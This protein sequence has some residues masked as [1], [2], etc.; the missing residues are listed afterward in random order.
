MKMLSSELINEITYINKDNDENNICGC[1][2]TYSIY[3]I[4]NINKLSIETFING[5]TKYAI[6]S[7][8][9]NKIILSQIEGFDLEVISKEEICFNDIRKIKITDDFLGEKIVNIRTEDTKYKFVIPKK[10]KIFNNIEFR[11]CFINRLKFQ[12]NI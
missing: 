12:M 6:A 2:T 3:P 5:K 1:Y 9:D 10:T 7:I 11:N 4:H 8:D